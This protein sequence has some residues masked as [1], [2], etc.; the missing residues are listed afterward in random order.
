MY[1]THL[2]II[3]EFLTI[4]SD[5]NHS[6]TVLIENQSF[7]MVKKEKIDVVDLQCELRINEKSYKVF[8]YRKFKA[9]NMEL[10]N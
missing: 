2:K 7:T 8:A 10:G 5:G 9:E 1:H 3:P 4:S 6:L